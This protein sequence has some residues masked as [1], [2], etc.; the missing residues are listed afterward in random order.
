MQGTAE[1]NA[2]YADNTCMRESNG[3][4]ILKE[5]SGFLKRGAGALRGANGHCHDVVFI[6][7][8]SGCG[9]G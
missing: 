4:I 2:S 1:S 5:F 9:F 8:V 3:P 6:I 7:K